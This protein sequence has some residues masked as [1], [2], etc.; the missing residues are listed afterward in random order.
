MATIDGNT[1]MKLYQN[2]HQH[3]HQSKVSS[4]SSV[5]SA[6]SFE[7]NSPNATTMPYMTM[8]QKHSAPFVPQP[9]FQQLDQINF[10]VRKECINEIEQAC[11]ELAI[12]AGK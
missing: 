7:W 11:D 9:Q 6:D 5:C 12:S 4:S 3:Q 8:P 2:H 10:L 1:M